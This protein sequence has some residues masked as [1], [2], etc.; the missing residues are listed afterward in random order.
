M[1]IRIRTFY[2]A[3]L[4]SI[5]TFLGFTGCSDPVDEYGTPTVEY[6]VI[7]EYFSELNVSGEIVSGDTEETKPVEGIR[8][9][10]MPNTANANEVGIP[11][12]RRDTAFTDEKGKF[13]IQGN[14]G[15]YYYHSGKF[16]LKIEDVDGDKNGLFENKEEL[17][18]VDREEYERSLAQVYPPLI[19]AKKEIGTIKL[20]PKK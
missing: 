3:I 7:P 11:A 9:I 6:G 18:E 2:S 19:T 13:E 15:Y 8:V 17:L 14:K 10:M 5:L 20:K 1:A 4:S 16:K 12:N